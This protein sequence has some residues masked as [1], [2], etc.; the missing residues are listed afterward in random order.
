M[1]THFF[2]YFFQNSCQLTVNSKLRE[3][4]SRQEKPTDAKR[5]LTTSTSFPHPDFSDFLSRSQGDVTY[6][7]KVLTENLKH[8]LLAGHHFHT[9]TTICTKPPFELRFLLAMVVKPAHVAQSQSQTSAPGDTTLTLTRTR[10]PSALLL[11]RRVRIVEVAPRDG[12]QNESVPLPASV[13][14]KLVHD[15]A[16]AGIKTVEVTAFVSPKKV[17]QLADA[18]KVMGDV[19]K[20]ANEENLYLACVPNMR[21]LKDAL[22]AGAKAIA[23]MAAATDVF[24]RNNVGVDVD[25]AIERYAQV[26]KKSRSEQPG[27]V[28]RAYVSCA[29][30]CPYFGNV[31]PS[32]V[33]N[34]ARRLL[35]IGCDEIALGDTIGAGNPR[36]VVDVIQAVVQAGVPV[37]R[38][39]VHF[40]D[41]RG[42]ALA[43]VLAALS[44]GVATVDSSIAGLGGCPFA[45]GSAG[46]LATEDLVHMLQGMQ[47][48]VGDVDLTKLVN[49]GNALCRRLGCETRSRVAQTLRAKS[50][51]VSL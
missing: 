31:P 19:L 33:G 12:L 4:D 1:L 15:L 36:T 10:V 6:L 46:N 44:M 2:A 24:S 49:V 47:V 18:K 8:P 35:D 16:D 50:N 28:V 13:K 43:N 14:V 41:T 17:P 38:I 27:I 23:L 11:P 45:P 20:S 21:G 30:G 39:A 40:H 37:H 48:D 9:R 7:T 25:T 51:S 42:I 26:V 5:K 3:E 32:Q 22:A 29:L 34:V